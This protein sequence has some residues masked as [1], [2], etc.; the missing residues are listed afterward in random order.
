MMTP[1]SESGFSLKW[2]LSTWNRDLVEEAGP[3]QG[4][5]PPF[6]RSLLRLVLRWWP[7]LLR[8]SLVAD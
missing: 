7:L 6:P 1:I 3:Q 2:E 8:V 5:S 4:V